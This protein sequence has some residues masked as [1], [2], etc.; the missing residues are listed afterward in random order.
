FGPPL[1][2]YY[3][4]FVDDLNMPALEVYGAQPPIE[5]LRQ[6]CDHKG[7]YDR[8]A[9]G[10]FREL[11]DIT[12][13]CA[14]GPP[15]GGRNPVTPRFLR[16]FNHLSFTELEDSS[17]QNIFSSILKSWLVNYT[18]EGKD[19]LN[20]ALVMGTLSVYNT[21]I[22]QVRL[23]PT[24]AK[25]HYTFNL[26]DLSKVF[27]GILMALPEKLEQ[28]ADLLRLWYHENCRVFQDRLVN[29]EDRLWFNDLMKVK[30]S[31]VQ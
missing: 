21:V 22:T 1:G 25:S 23:L 17:K 14:M 15:G 29:D 3:V 28:K 2:K 30:T 12:F 31:S 16:H 20:N 7:W 10:V 4:L 26:R 6:Y 19:L 18:G 13:V 24:P 11:V 5:I 27:Q 8:K 9:I